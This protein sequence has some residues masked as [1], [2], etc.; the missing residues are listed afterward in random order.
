MV[1]LGLCLC[2]GEDYWDEVPFSIQHSQGTWP[3]TGEVS[4]LHLAKVPCVWL[5]YCV[6]VFY[7]PPFYIIWNQATKHSPH[8]KDEKL[9]STPFKE[10]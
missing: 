10:Q 2:E 6:K 5:L 9:R 8:M 4:L 3:V 7:F 1:G